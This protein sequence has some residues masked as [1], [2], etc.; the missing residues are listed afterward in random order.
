MAPV[1]LG[2]RQKLVVATA[3]LVIV[4]LAVGLTVWLTSGDDKSPQPSHQEYAKLFANALLRQTKISYLDK[5][6]EPYQVYH[7]SYQ[8]RCYEWWDKPILLY[9]LC[10][11]NNG[12]LVNKDIL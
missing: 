8:H 10:F 9:S 7:D 4:A 2:K 3:V 1:R 11:G 6:P 12:V 5:W